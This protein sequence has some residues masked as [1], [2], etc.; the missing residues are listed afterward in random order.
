MSITNT[1]TKYFTSGQIKFSAIRDTFG[2][3]A[4]TDVRASDYARN[5]GDN[6][7]WEAAGETKTISPRVPNATENADVATLSSPVSISENVNVT[8]TQG[9]IVI[10]NFNA[11]TITVTRYNDGVT[12]TEG[13]AVGSIGYFV[14]VSNVENLNLSV[15]VLDTATRGS[16]LTASD[17]SIA[18]STGYPQTI[19]SKRFKVAFDM[20]NSQGPGRQATYARSFQL[21]ISG[22]DGGI[23]D[24]KTSQLRDS[25]VEYNI[26]QSGT[27]EELEF[28]DTNVPTWNDN[29]SKNVN[30]KMS[31]EGTIYANEVSKYA[32]KFS[33]GEYNNL[34][35]H[36]PDGGKIY[37]EGGAAGGGDGGGALYVR[38][39]TSNRLVSI[40]LGTN[41]Q[42]WAGGGG[43]GNGNSGNS[44][45]TLSCF[46]NSSH[47][48]SYGFPH[49]RY[50]NA[51]D[52]VTAC[53]ANAPSG[54]YDVVVATATPTDLRGR[55]R[56][57]GGYRAGHGWNSV[58]KIGYGCSPNWSLSCSSK[59]ANNIAGGN[60]GTGGTGGVGQ[61]FSNQSGPG[62]GNS[63]N[64][65]N[66]NTCNATGA[67]S[68][69]NSGNSGG[70]GG[71][72]GV[73]GSAGGGSA[74]FSILKRFA[75]INQ[76]F[77]LN[78]IKGTIGNMIV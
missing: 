45:S 35:I 66:T 30:K 41:G 55:C 37:G 49:H 25:I 73:A 6:V 31:V 57:G 64:S 20:T 44:G 78:T 56:G 62:S 17:N 61:G 39:M 14:D 2:D 43:G 70:T 77:S 3:L 53:R 24:W 19:T 36:V 22:D 63:G 23:N 8:D 1:Q 42:I 54:S 69:G 52:A 27:D 7:D 48:S 29:L 4:G 76:G 9:S 58:N 67:N 13:H 33:E 68:S 47:N 65:G 26:T 15:T 74:G 60:G 10:G 21:S 18:L 32:L 50:Y 51:G 75:N 59:I 71:T 34:T 5:A 38:N 12:G 40:T 28:A 46:T 11:G 72:W 16:G